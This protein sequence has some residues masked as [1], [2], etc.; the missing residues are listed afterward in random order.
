A[1]RD[2]GGEQDLVLLTHSRTNS[3]ELA[4]MIRP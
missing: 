2:S 1:F 4:S 3:D